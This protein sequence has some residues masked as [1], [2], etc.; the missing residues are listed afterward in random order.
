MLTAR[1]EDSAVELLRRALGQELL[2]KEHHRSCCVSLPLLQISKMTSVALIVPAL[3]GC[4]GVASRQRSDLPY[5][6]S[7]T[8]HRQ[9][10]TR[11]LFYC[12]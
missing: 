1:L 4:P 5:R 7:L 10:D 11:E 9:S 8:S 12:L 3:Q 2:N 6:I